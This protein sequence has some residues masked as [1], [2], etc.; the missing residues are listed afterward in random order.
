MRGFETE[1]NTDVCGPVSMWVCVRVD[2]CPCVCVHACGSVRMCMCA[3]LLVRACWQS[4]SQGVYLFERMCVRVG[5]W[6]WWRLCVWV[7][8]G[9]CLVRLFG[10]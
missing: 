5:L 8:V 4:M 3:R 2:V 10:Q 1:M 9:V 6:V 7:L